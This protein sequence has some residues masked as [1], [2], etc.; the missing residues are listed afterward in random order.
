MPVTRMGSEDTA[1]NRTKKCSLSSWCFISYYFLQHMSRCN[2]G[3][4]SVY[5]SG[6]YGIQRTSTTGSALSPI[7]TCKGHHF[8]CSLCCLGHCVPTRLFLYICNLC[9]CLEHL[10]LCFAVIVLKCLIISPLNLCFV[11]EV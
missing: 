10:V 3:R 11:S 1:I 4:G 8:T 7:L 9:C 2:M 5:A 6:T